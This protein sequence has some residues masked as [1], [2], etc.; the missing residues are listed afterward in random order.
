MCCSLYS[1]VQSALRDSVLFVGRRFR[2]Y[3]VP[4]LNL[5][6]TT[7]PT[8]L[9]SQDVFDMMVLA[10]VEIVV[11]RRRCEIGVEGHSY[12]RIEA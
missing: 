5:C 8:H 1:R 9:C 7:A 2:Q 3:H 6:A 12:T 10:I 11:T 4:K